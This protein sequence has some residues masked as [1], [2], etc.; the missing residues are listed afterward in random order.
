MWEYL[1]KYLHPHN[2][3]WPD[4][5]AGPLGGNKAR[6]REATLAASNESFSGAIAVSSTELKIKGWMY[7]AG[8]DAKF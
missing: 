3:K 4:E 8:L 7:T 5:N 6:G 2:D 1:R